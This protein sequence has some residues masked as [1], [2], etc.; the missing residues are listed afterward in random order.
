MGLPNKA[1]EET[2][3]AAQGHVRNR[4]GCPSP[5]GKRPSTSLVESGQIGPRTNQRG[6]ATGSCSSVEED[7][8]GRDEEDSK[9][10]P[11]TI[12]AR[13]GSYPDQEVVQEEATPGEIPSSWRVLFPI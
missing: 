12:S 4:F 11:V 3:Q 2:E 8:G 10:S 1:L 9:P 5:N 6:K 13:I 7:G